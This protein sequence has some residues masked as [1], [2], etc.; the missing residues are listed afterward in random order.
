[1]SAWL[2]VRYPGFLVTGVANTDPKGHVDFETFWRSTVALL[3]GADT[4]RTGSVLPNLN[5]PFLSLLLAP[6]GALPVLPSYWV[7]TALTVLVVTWSVLAAARELRLGAGATVFGL[8]AMWACSPL[9]GTLL[10]GQIY[11][12]LLAGLTAA[13][14]AQRR[15]REQLCAVLLGVVVAVKP[16]LAPLLLIPLVQRRGASAERPSLRW[17]ALW[18][19]L[20][21]AGAASLVGVLAAGPSSALAW[22]RLA[23]STPAPEVDANASLPGLVARI[24]GPGALGWLVTVVVVAGSL[25]WVRR[26]TPPPVTAPGTVGPA[27]AAI[28]AV[29]AGCLLAAP[30]AWLNYLVMLWPGAL[31]LL[32][33]GRWRIAVPLLVLPVVPVAWNNLWMAEPHAVVALLG[34]SLYCA[35]LLGYWVALLA[36]ASVSSGSSSGPVPGSPSSHSTPA[37]GT[38]STAD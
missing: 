21:S 36:F 3:H 15:G 2:F 19:G 6:L 10:L 38:L 33:G 32:R 30:I 24:G 29:A 37:G 5:P 27:D 1:M 12:L 7:F 14:L 9:H 4:Y 26:A 18:S 25:W 28:F 17:P 35:V 8:V 22:L 11:G 20:A 16:S 13:W 23:G 34:R 31:A